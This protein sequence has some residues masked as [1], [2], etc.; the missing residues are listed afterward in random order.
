M[1]AVIAGTGVYSLGRKIE[2]R[3][4]VTPHG[5]AT[6]EIVKLLGEEVVFLPR[7]GRNHQ[8]PPHMINYCA[9]IAALEKIGVRGV[10]SFYSAGII[11]NYRPGDLVLVD[12]F[13]GLWTPATFYDDF[14]AGMKHADFTEP[15]SRD[16]NAI[17]EEVAAVNRIDLK[18]GGIMAATPGPRFETRS[19]IR[20]LRNAG[21]NLVNMTC[22]YE[23]ALLGESE[24]DFAAV[25]VASNY[26][27]G[28][29][30]KPLSAEETMAVV[31]E[32][33]GKLLTLVQGFMKEIV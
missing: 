7:H 26:A 32:S 8:T 25:A 13:I 5:I 19:E 24:I 33:K 10:L 9:N 28:I 18:K 31:K 3:D 30:E 1:L 12:D 29:S 14:S 23:M 4:V 15:F 22:G 17:L 16:M 21:A 11:S 20:L 2:D 27:A 6:L